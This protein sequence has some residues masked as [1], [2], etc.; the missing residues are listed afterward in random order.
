MPFVLTCT[1]RRPE[2]PTSDNLPGEQYVQQGLSP[3]GCCP[4]LILANL[5]VNV[6]TESRIIGDHSIGTLPTLATVIR[7]SAINSSATN[8]LSN[9]SPKRLM[10]S[11]A[12]VPTTATLVSTATLPL[13]AC[14]AANRSVSRSSL[15]VD[16]AVSQPPS[17]VNSTDA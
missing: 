10:S 2:R 1:L 11:S 4:F 15:S 14:L 12:F 16:I 8:T 6:P 5:G 7:A 9:A 17:I 13:I 3:F